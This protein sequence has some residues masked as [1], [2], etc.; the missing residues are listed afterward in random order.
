MQRRTAGKA[1]AA[2]LAVIGLVVLLG[3]GAGLAY[4]GIIPLPEPLA[5]R[6]GIGN[7]EEPLLEEEPENGE[8]PLEQVASAP[9]EAEL[10]PVSLTSEPAPSVM[11]EAA[12]NSARRLAKVWDEVRSA[13]LAAILADWTDDNAA[14]IVARM[15]P[16][17]TAKLLE[18]LPPDRASRLSAAVRREITR[19]EA[20]RLAATE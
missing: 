11:G 17:K 15:D 12:D 18:A 4:F 8:A 3:A 5:A 6:L 2:L 1:K 10:R 7:D 19:S 20:R 16:T 13:D 14:P 9:E